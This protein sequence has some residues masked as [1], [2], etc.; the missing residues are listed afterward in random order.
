MADFGIPQSR[1]R[2]VLL[3]GLGFKIPFPEP[4]RA[5]S[6]KEGSALRPWNTVRE[7]IGH[8]GEPITL[9]TANAA[10]AVRN[11][12]TCTWSEIF[13]HKYR[14]DCKQRKP[15]QTWL[16]NLDESVR[17]QCHRN[18]YKGFTNMYG[19]M[20]WDQAAPTITG[21][22]TDIK[23]GPIR[24]PY[25]RRLTISVREAALLQTFPELV[26]ASSRPEWMLCAISSAMRCHHFMLN[27]P[28][29]R[30]WTLSRA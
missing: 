3:A 27:K 12:I 2:L 30:F 10:T 25:K 13:S 15:G 28:P 23:Q 20:E 29:R 16:G 11:R 26:T 1:R 21:G 9:K 18:G 17:P 7:A 24:T 22:C 6:P 5:R 14:K 8:M 19:R 4:T